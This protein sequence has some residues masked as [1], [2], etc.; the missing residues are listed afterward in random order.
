[1]GKKKPKKIPGSRTPKSSVSGTFEQV[2]PGFLICS[3]LS[4]VLD[5]GAN[6]DRAILAFCHDGGDPLTTTDKLYTTVICEQ[7]SQRVESAVSLFEPRKVVSRFKRDVL[8]DMV[9]DDQDAPV[10]VI[11]ENIEAS[12]PARNYYVAN[13]VEVALWHN[14]YVSPD[15][16][17]MYFLSFHFT[18]KASNPVI[19]P[20]VKQSILNCVS[21]VALLVPQIMSE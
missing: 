11:P 13:G 10:L 19:A 3:A 20:R 9:R 1:M 8:T 21:E 17:K 14:V 4:R 16:S 2:Q 6:L 18:G 12:D 5:L 7:R 15:K